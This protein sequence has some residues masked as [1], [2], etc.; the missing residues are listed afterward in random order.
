MHRR[1]F[2]MT[3]VLR[4]H[5]RESCLVYGERSPLIFS[6]VEVNDKQVCQ[7]GHDCTNFLSSRITGLF[8]GSSQSFLKLLLV[9]CFLLFGG[10]FLPFDLVL[11]EGR[12]YPRCHV[13]DTEKI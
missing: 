10:N 8:L 1:V 2:S 9:F 6:V 3:V 13:V 11:D 12:L 7:V 5:S 4:G